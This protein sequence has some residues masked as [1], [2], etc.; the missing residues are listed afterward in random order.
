MDKF[1]VKGGRRLTGEV[2]I[3]GAKN[4]AVAILP[5]VIL[6]D[7]PCVIENVPSIS[8]V[9]ISLRI[10]S[11]MGAEVTNIGKD[12]YRID[13]TG[14][15]KCCVPYETARKMR[16]SYYFLGA[17]LGKFNQARVSMP[18]GCPLGDRPIDQHLKAFS[19][20]GAEYN[21]SQGMI[22]LSADKLTGNQIFFDVVT[23]GATMNAMLAAV[24][25][26][27]LTVIENAAK[28]P[29]IVDLA[30]FLNSMGANI[31]GAGTDVIKIRGV[32]RLHGTNYAVIPDQIE[33]GTFMI[34]AAATKGDVL[35]KNVIP[36]HLESIT[37]KLEKIGVNIEQ[38]DD[39][40]RVWCDGPLVKA[41]V[42]TT[43]HPG[44]PTDMQPQI[45]TLL[46]LAEGTS[47]VTEGVWEQRF[48][49][50]DELRRMGA[51]I[52]VNGK[53]AL[54]E[55][56]GR[57]MGAPVKACDLRAGAA[58]IIAGLAAQ[59]VTE[60][61]DIFHIERGYDCMEGKLRALNAEIEKVSVPDKT[62][63]KTD[64]KTAV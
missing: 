25:A 48:R 24:K 47:I 43:P 49:Y 54:V 59:G 22:D 60:I 56:T 52:T 38:Y 37:K 46:T 7:E 36:K 13:P 27:G 33:A 42:K 17:L 6:S 12:A 50:V 8:D 63:N 3:S 61:E 1:I 9:T 14:I 21:L 5:A 11:E 53:V 41:N 19:A 45:A 64:K 58:L 10:L 34:A 16:A 15:D 28:E 30:N 23:V 2:T 26:E 39:S 4:A 29:H 44:F 20:L 31:M 57:L 62:S 40:I 18:G 55:G 51:N 35:I 32:E